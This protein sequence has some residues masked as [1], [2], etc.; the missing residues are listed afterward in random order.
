VLRRAPGNPHAN[1]VQA[2]LFFRQKNY[3]KASEFVQLA[4][5]QQPNHG[6]ATL[7]T[8]MVGMAQGSVQEAESHLKLWL[9][10]R[11][12]DV[13]ARKLYA[14]ALL[15]RNNSQG[16]V[17]A[18]APALDSGSGDAGLFELAAEAYAKTKDF[19]RSQALLDKA[20]ELREK[21]PRALVS[22]GLRQ[23]AEGDAARGMAQLEKAAALDSGD[24]GAD[25][26]LAGAL[27]RRGEFEKALAAALRMEKKQPSSPIPPTLAGAALLSAGDK[28]QARKSF[29]RAAAL[30]AGYLPAALS[31]AQLD[32]EERRPDAARKRIEAVVARDKTNFQALAALARISG[33]STQLITS[34]EA[35]R[36]HDRKALVPRLALVDQYLAQGQADKAL[37]VAQETTAALPDNVDAL[38]A[39]GSAQLAAGRKNDAVASFGKVVAAAPESSVARVRLAQAH[40]AVGNTRA[41]ES[42]YRKA[43]G[44]K[45]DD[46]E[47]GMGL[48]TLYAQGG[49]LGD[50]MKI[51]KAIQK[52]LPRLAAGY[53]LEGD[54]LVRQQKFA[55]AA[56]AYQ[57]GFT[58]APTGF[59]LTKLHAARKTGGQD[60]G[61]EQLQQW[62]NDHPADSGVRMFL[63]D[64]QLVA[65]QIKT[66]IDNYLLVVKAEPTNARALNNLANA[67]LA[68]KDARAVE[69]AQAAYKLRPGDPN[70]IDTLGWALTET[71]KAARGAEMLKTAVELAP[72][73]T[74][75]RLHYAVALAK[76][77]D[78]QRARLEVRRLIDA[79]KDVKLD[80]AMRALLQ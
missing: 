2:L 73:S 10:V 79:G 1:H 28:A 67:Y 65:G 11:P 54:L 75:F 78:K 58:A 20:V 72:D 71:G 7:L 69:T 48:A 40:V 53:L 15:K 37:A 29:E 33:D 70:V 16:A 80:A 59:L 9:Q 24:F 34:L 56:K 61:Q 76:S 49:A 17:E 52:R 68:A 32:M 57:A 3:D 63:A 46:V 19:S 26:A 5:K 77:G 39:L 62:L 38:S 14:S 8:G 25:Y 23:L 35:A 55:D 31:L 18:L 41:A 50:A 42:E 47:A 4:L 13:F 74:E 22:L 64:Q 36:K 43:I 12:G 30:D 21:D 45:P 27:L 6:P 44:L 60:P 51:A 66:A